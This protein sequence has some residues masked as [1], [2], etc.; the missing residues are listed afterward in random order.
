MHATLAGVWACSGLQTSIT[1]L[2]PPELHGAHDGWAQE[3]A[4]KIFSPLHVTTLPLSSTAFQTGMEQ[5]HS[6]LAVQHATQEACE[7]AQHA[8]WEARED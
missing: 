4:K 8:N 6:D 2:L 3:Q 1:Q 7:L 5:L